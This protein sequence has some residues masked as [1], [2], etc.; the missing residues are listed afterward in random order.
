MVKISFIFLGKYYK[1]KDLG[2]KTKGGYKDCKEYKY[3]PAE[4][5]IK[6]EDEK[7]KEMKE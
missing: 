1:I 5:S 6:T 4:I 7:V 2:L 3:V